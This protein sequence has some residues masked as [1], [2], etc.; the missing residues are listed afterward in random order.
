MQYDQRQ[1]AMG[2]PTS[3]QKEKHDVLKSFMS[4]VGVLIMCVCVCA[5]ENFSNFSYCCCKVGIL[6]CEMKLKFKK[7]SRA[8]S[9]IRP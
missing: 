5:C 1:K 9:T 7:N 8:V 2:L 3:D 6:D 4:Q